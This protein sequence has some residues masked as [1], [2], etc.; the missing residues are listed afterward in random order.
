MGSFKFGQIRAD[1]N[2]LGPVPE[3]PRFDLYGIKLS[4]D[5][6]TWIESQMA[7]PNDQPRSSGSDFEMAAFM[8]ATMKFAADDPKLYYI[9]MVKFGQVSPE[10]ILA[11]VELAKRLEP[12]LEEAVKD[13]HD[14]YS[15]YSEH[16]EGRPGPLEMGI[17][18]PLQLPE[19]IGLKEEIAEFFAYLYLVDKTSF[20]PDEDF[21]SYVDKDGKPAYSPEEA[22]ARNILMTEAFQAAEAEGLDLYEVALWVGALAGVNDDPENEAQAPDWIKALSN[23]WI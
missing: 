4:V 14:R 22:K 16:R 9:R 6:D 2:R 11:T 17:A 19:H 7:R 10:E 5:E 18:R 20:H 23:T 15:L 12:Y 13:A 3:K 21:E 8:L 1:V